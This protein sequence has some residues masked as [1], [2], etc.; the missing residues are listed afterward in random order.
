MTIFK[1]HRKYNNIVSIML[2]L[3]KG[4]NV[5]KIS[6]N[7]VSLR[8]IAPLSYTRWCSYK[9][10][11]TAVQPDV[12]DNESSIYPPIKTPYPPGQ[13]GDISKSYA[14]H[15]HEQ[16]ESFKKVPNAKERLEKLAGKETVWLNKIQ[17]YNRRPRTLEFKQFVTNTHI[18]SG[19]PDVYKNDLNEDTFTSIKSLIEETLLEVN[20][21]QYMY[22]LNGHN[23]LI[24]GSHK[25]VKN[26]DVF[27]R[28]LQKAMALLSPSHTYLTHAQ[29]DEEVRC[30]AFWRKN[31]FEDDKTPAKGKW[32]GM[33]NFQI[34]S[35]IDWQVRTE[36]PLK[37]V[38]FAHKMVLCLKFCDYSRGENLPRIRGFPRIW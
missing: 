9:K 6:K 38:C 3:S 25:H 33:L 36:T 2:S 21:Y 1:R 35:E 22:K 14:W 24:K 37:P 28:I 18:S 32:L 27:G 23:K 30:E 34:K 31:G 7:V 16:S 13:W 19:Q 15:I 17:A 26:H 10:Y 4:G 12:A 8:D 20:E 5:I 29:I 11:C